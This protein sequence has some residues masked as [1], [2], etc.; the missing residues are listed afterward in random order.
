MKN[1]FLL[2]FATV[3]F[4]SPSLYGQFDDLY[5]DEDTDGTYYDDS[6]YS[7]DSDDYDYYYED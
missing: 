4:I 2:A 3:L 7:D 6:E 5:Y 1:L